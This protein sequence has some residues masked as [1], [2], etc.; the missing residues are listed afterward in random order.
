MKNFKA[1]TIRLSADQSEQLNT[2]A[3]VQGQAVSQ[4][5]RSAIAEHI[6]DCKHDTA[7]QE[8]LRQRIHRARK[9]L[10]DDE[11][12]DEENLASPILDHSPNRA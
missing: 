6:E 11:R 3:A 4:V 10:T 1:M 9:L 8:M 7:F 12:Q 5:I 2:I